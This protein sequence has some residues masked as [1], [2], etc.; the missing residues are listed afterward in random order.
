MSSIV[1]WAR[2]P[3]VWPVTTF[4]LLALEAASRS[5]PC[6]VSASQCPSGRCAYPVIDRSKAFAVL[7]GSW[8]GSQPTQ[9]GPTGFVELTPVLAEH[10]VRFR[11][12]VPVRGPVLNAAA[13]G[14][15][16]TEDPQRLPGPAQPE[17]ISGPLH[18]RQRV[19]RHLGRP[20]RGTV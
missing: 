20:L 12:L 5:D 9:L 19:R 4:L 3:R 11:H 16:L 1:K 7:M 17:R 2:I 13:P 18:V 15:D 14:I 8:S 6:P 10:V